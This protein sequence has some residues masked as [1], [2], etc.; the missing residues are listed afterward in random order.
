MVAHHIITGR[1][2]ETADV[3]AIGTVSGP[4]EEPHSEA[5]L[6]EACK[7]GRQPITLVTTTG[8]NAQT[9]TFLEDGDEIKITGSAYDPDSKLQIGFGEC[10]R[11]LL[12]AVQL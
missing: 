11:Q 5:S 12:P 7:A 6:I 8:E 1:N 3:F 9:R 4:F 2:L 10:I